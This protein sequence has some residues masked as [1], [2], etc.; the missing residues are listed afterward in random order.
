MREMA[1]ETEFES[2]SP[3]GAAYEMPPEF[4]TSPAATSWP[5][6][7]PRSGRDIIASARR[8]RLLRGMDG[9]SSWSLSTRGRHEAKAPAPAKAYDHHEAAIAIVRDW[10]AV[11]GIDR[12]IRLSERIRKAALAGDALAGKIVR[13]VLDRTGD[14]QRADNVRTAANKPRAAAPAPAVVGL[15]VNQLRLTEQSARAHAQLARDVAAGL[16]DLTARDRDLERPLSK[17]ERRK[18]LVTV[19]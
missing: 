13:H 6:L 17:P 10:L 5:G 19:P 12:R 18:P 2:P 16:L 15:T 14:A 1:P 11:H 7:S 4:P 8:G 3:P 9:A